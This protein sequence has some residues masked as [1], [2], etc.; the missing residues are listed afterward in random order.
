MPPAP[1]AWPLRA[2]GR[3]GH[4][5]PVRSSHSLALLPT[6]RLPEAG[7]HATHSQGMNQGSRSSSPPGAQTVASFQAS[8]VHLFYN[9]GTCLVPHCLSRDTAT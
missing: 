8:W 1:Q 2:Q 3:W 4:A 6:S 9:S 5:C 7:V